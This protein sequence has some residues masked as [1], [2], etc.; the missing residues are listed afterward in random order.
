MATSPRYEPTL[1]TSG[2]DAIS[3]RMIIHLGHNVL[4]SVVIR[5]NERFQNRNLISDKA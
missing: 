5:L 4:L 1:A 3:F 2:E